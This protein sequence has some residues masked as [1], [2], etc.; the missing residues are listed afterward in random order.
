MIIVPIE[1]SRKRELQ[2][3]SHPRTWGRFLRGKRDEHVLPIERFQKKGKWK[4]IGNEYC[5]LSKSQEEQMEGMGTR[6]EVQKLILKRRVYI[7]Y[8]ESSGKGE[9]KWWRMSII[10]IE[11][12]RKEG[13]RDEYRYI[14]PSKSR[15][16]GRVYG[17]H[18]KVKKT[19]WMP[20]VNVPIKKPIKRTWKGWTTYHI[21]NKWKGWATYHIE[22]KKKRKKNKLKKRREKQWWVKTN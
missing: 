21:E 4:K 14:Y 8:I 7:M 2:N 17:S 10:L 15:E 16:R 3:L 18:R 22:S 11:N 6:Q 1:K 5:T 12:P 19:R 13:E 9:R 20:L